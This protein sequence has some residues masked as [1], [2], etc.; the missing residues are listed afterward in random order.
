M[1]TFQSLSDKIQSDEFIEDMRKA[2][3]DDISDMLG[4]SVAKAF[5]FGDQHNPHHDRTLKDHILDVVKAISRDDPTL[6]IAA[7]LHDIGKPEAATWIKNHSKIIYNG[8]A[9]MSKDLARPILEGMD[10]DPTSKKEIEFFV[11]QHDALMMI[12]P[13]DID[14]IYNVFDHWDMMHIPVMMQRRIFDLMKADAEAQAASVTKGDGT[15][16]TREDKISKVAEFRRI[17]DERAGL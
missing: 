11:Y 16:E 7:L 8:H 6:R 14:G 5:A 2:S 10:A 4:E 9:A 3:N 15:V 13:K 12:D 1:I 17:F